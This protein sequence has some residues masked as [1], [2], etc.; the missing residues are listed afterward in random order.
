MRNLDAMSNFNTI[1]AHSWRHKISS[2]LQEF[3]N[4]EASTA[5]KLYTILKYE[6]N[7]Y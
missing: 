3:C 5:L 4:T 1:L 6:L 7:I 2:I